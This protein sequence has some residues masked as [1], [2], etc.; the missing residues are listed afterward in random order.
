M[1]LMDILI[2]AALFVLLLLVAYA[3][4]RTNKI[5]KQQFE[6]I[7]WAAHVNDRIARLEQLET[8]DEGTNEA[9]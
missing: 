1:A 8:D 2:W 3:S 9:D 5:E 6:A 4:G 7:Q